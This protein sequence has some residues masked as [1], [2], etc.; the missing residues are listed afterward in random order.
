MIEKAVLPGH[1]EFDALVLQA[2][3]RKQ[4]AASSRKI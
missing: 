3:V 1:G 2:L 4:P